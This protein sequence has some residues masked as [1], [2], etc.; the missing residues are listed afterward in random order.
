MS[1]RVPGGAE[2]DIA[3]G[4]ARIIGLLKPEQSPLRDVG[5]P[6]RTLRGRATRGTRVFAMVLDGWNRGSNDKACLSQR[7][8]K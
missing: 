1:A 4:R 3:T 6:T 2:D 5:F 7:A 8:L